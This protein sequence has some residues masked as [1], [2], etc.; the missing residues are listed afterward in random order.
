MLDSQ[1]N[2]SPARGVEEAASTQTKPTDRN[3]DQE[4]IE[5]FQEA[6]EAFRATERCV[7]AGKA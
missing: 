5:A 1:S 6:L 4:Q 7:K 2:P 3:Q